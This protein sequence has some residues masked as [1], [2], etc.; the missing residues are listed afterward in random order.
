MFKKI[1]ANTVI[2]SVAPYIASFANLLILPLITKELTEVDYGISGT[3][4]AYTSALSALSVLG[5]S[6]VLNN[7]FFHHKHHY[8]FV[9]RQMYG[10]LIIWNLIYSFILGVF[11]YSFM[12]LAAAENTIIIIFLNVL[13]IAFFGPT[14]FLGTT[15]YILEQKSLP[16]GIRTAIFGILAVILNLLFIVHYKFGY[17]A[18]FYTNFIIGI[19]TNVSYWFVLNK[20]IGITPIF[21]FKYRTIKES[22]KISLP[23][24]P[25]QYSYYLLNGS[26]RLMMD[27][28]KIDISKIGE[29]N[30][31]SSFSNYASNLAQAGS[32]A[33]APVLM[34]LYKMQKFRQARDIVFIYQFVLLF[35]N[36]FVCLWMKEVFFILIHNDVLRKTYDIAIILIM[37]VSFTPLFVG[38]FNLLLF[39]EKTK[40]I[41]IITLIAGIICVIL[42]LIFLPIYGVTSAAIIIF[43]AYM[44]RG[45]AG[46]YLSSFKQVSTISYYPLM[47]TL[48][49]IISTIAIFLL[50]DLSL[51][52]KLILTF[53][54]FIFFLITYSK[55]EALKQKIR[56]NF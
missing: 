16:I 15:Y 42:N 18:W 5:I 25:H 12:P 6:V 11:L 1:L 36:L 49:I 22:L 38:Y 28:V 37:S 13:P 39:K 32:T 34:N 9:W 45:I 3:I 51:T 19:L 54:G 40:N 56:N 24:V 41:W 10:F 46:Y 53:F 8:K 48:I 47:W 31:A 52:N 20:K 7:S 21:N 27:Q 23:L 30:I 4:M 29:F 35:V 2:Y 55:R 33:I 44:Y 43:I 50:K 17:M 14:N 26:E